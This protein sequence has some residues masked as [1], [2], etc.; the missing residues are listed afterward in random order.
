ML[1][2]LKETKRKLF[3]WLFIPKGLKLRRE[4][5]KM[6]KLK[7]FP[8]LPLKKELIMIIT[9]LK[10]QLDNVG[11]QWLQMNTI[12]WSDKENAILIKM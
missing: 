5:F 2:L 3:Q 11:A 8:K 10:T 4:S 7:S 6:R 9:G 1:L 12:L